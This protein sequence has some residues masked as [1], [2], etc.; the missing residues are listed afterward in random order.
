MRFL[1][2]AFV[3][4][5]AY[6][7]SSQK[8]SNRFSLGAGQKFA[9]TINSN[10]TTEMMMGES[11]S[12]SLVTELYI[13]SAKTDSTYTFEQTL[14]RMRVEISIM[15]QEK[16]IDTDKPEDLDD[17]LAQPMKDLKST[18]NEIT[19]NHQGTIQDL[20]EQNKKKKEDDA[21]DMMGMFFQQLNM[22]N[23][24]PMPGGSIFFKVLPDYE[25]SVGDSWTDSTTAGENS[26]KTVY[27]LKEI[28][29]NEAIVNYQGSGTINTK[30]D[31]M[32]MSIEV[33]G[34]STTAGTITLDRATG[35]LKQKTITSIIDTSSEV[36]GQS[37]D[38]N[39]K[40]TSVMTVT[41][42]KI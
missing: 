6:T 32:G 4:S 39:T 7:A 20:K 31:M 33:K 24:K 26:F 13:V 11:T 34:T 15:G 2:F 41:E 40:T 38:S 12:S 23:S 14:E 16:V 25:V 28:K 19:I 1:L 30:Q 5:F 17:M 8:L 22:A 18:R 29:D 9:V 42:R 35:M 36:A 3:I 21:S 37:F 10:T 27:I